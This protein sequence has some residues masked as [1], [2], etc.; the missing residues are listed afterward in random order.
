MVAN[1]VNGID[2]ASLHHTARLCHDRAHVPAV[3]YSQ[4]FACMVHHCGLTWP[5]VKGSQP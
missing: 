2:G 3:A 1:H 4:H 5:V